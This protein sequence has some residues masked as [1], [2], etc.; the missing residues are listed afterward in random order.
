MNEKALQVLL[1]ADCHRSTS[2]RSSM[3]QQAE[4]LPAEPSS[5]PAHEARAQEACCVAQEHHPVLGEQHDVVGED[6]VEK[7]AASTACAAFW[8]RWRVKGSRR[9]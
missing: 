8:C 4:R 2:Q 6:G 9:A 5:M 1:H 7:S 3:T